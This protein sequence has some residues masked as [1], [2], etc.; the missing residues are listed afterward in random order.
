MDNHRAIQVDG[1]RK[2]FGEVQAVQGVTFGVAEGEI[3]SVLGT[4]RPAAFSS[5]RPA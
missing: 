2:R 4:R 5:R 1:L 3:F